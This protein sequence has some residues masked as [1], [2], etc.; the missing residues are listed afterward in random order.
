M[1]SSSCLIRNLLISGVKSNDS[2]EHMDED[3]T[4]FYIEPMCCT[5]IKKDEDFDHTNSTTILIFLTNLT[6]APGSLTEKNSSY[7]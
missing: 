7:K 2:L 3:L 5:Y 4:S 6:D 1:Y